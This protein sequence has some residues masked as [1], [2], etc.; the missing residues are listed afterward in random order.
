M[1]VHAN[2]YEVFRTILLDFLDGNAIGNN[3]RFN[4]GYFNRQ[5]NNSNVLNLLLPNF[6]SSRSMLSEEIS[7]HSKSTTLFNDAY[8]TRSDLF[9]S[10]DEALD[11]LSRED[12]QHVKSI[13][14]FTAGH[15]NLGSGGREVFP[16]EKALRLKIPI[17]VVQYY[18]DHG[19][20]TALSAQPRETLG[21]LIRIQQADE[22]FNTINDWYG[23]LD[24]RVHGYHYRFSYTSQHDKHDGAPINLFLSVR[25]LERVKV[26]VFAPVFSLNWWIRQNL[27]LF[28]AMVVALVAA[29]AVSIFLIMRNIKRQKEATEQIQLQADAANERAAAANAKADEEKRIRE[30]QEALRIKTE[31]EEAERQEMERLVNLMHTKNLFPRLQCTMGEERL[32]YVISKP[33]TTIGRRD[34]NDLALQQSTVSREHAKIVFNGAGFEIINLSQ[35]NKII[36]NGQFIEH[37][38]LK[39]GDIIGLGEVV[40]TFF[41]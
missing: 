2:Q 19:V 27:A 11:L 3:D 28:I 1:A 33:V 30:Q 39:N 25:N 36:V 14:V 7:S 5:G 17:F 31:K 12:E 37:T 21:D 9:A 24:A 4:V 38:A 32:S 29:I 10:I 15:N 34:D 23:S 6:T 16:S 22:A 26:D 40:I 20:A 41:M 8:R 13:F 18:R 35:T